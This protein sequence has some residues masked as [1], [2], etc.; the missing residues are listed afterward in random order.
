MVFPFCII[1][2]QL[3][4]SGIVLVFSNP[5]SDKSSIVPANSN[6]VKV[7]D[8]VGSSYTG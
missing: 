4:A 3:I 7:D 5:R 1:G 8:V 2:A 6:N